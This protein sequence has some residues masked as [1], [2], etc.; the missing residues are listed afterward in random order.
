MLT[1]NLHGEHKKITIIKNNTEQ[2]QGNLQSHNATHHSIMSSFR[3]LVHAAYAHVACEIQTVHQVTHQ[4]MDA[5]T[6]K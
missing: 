5:S 1:W 2:L 4:S 6:Q 3:N